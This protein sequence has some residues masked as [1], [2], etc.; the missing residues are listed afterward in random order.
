VGGYDSRVPADAVWC[1][2]K[3]LG[4]KY[5]AYEVYEKLVELGDAGPVLSRD[6]PVLGAER[7]MLWRDV[8]LKLIKVLDAV[9]LSL[10]ELVSTKEN[11]EQFLNLVRDLRR[12]V[13]V[14]RLDYHAWRVSRE[15]QNQ[16]VFE[17]AILQEAMYLR[18]HLLN[19]EEHIIEV[20]HRYA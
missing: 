11:L 3:H 16:P 17:S 10:E 12:A 20:L 4:G 2:A 18:D 5:H 15:Q 9:D 13:L 1:I 19:I 8:F 14:F 7:G 6:L